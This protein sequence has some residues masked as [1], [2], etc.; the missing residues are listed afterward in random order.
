MVV[1]WTQNAFTLHKPVKKTYPR[2]KTIVSGLGLQ[3][4]AGLIDFSAL[5]KFNDGFRYVVVLIDVFSKCVYVEC[6]KNKTA[7]SMICAFSKL[8]KRSKHFR[9]LQTDRG[10][11]F[12]NHAFQSWLKKQKIHFFH[13]HNYDVQSGIVEKVVRTLNERLWRYF[14]HTNTPRYIDIIQDLEHS[15][16]PE[17]DVSRR[18]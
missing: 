12:T 3:M 2:R 4:Q 9:S 15:Y 14:T 16:N 7:Q 13:S 1:K 11:E 18:V 10:S 5:K 17:L 6:V 8:L